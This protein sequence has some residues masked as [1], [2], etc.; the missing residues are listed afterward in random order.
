MIG[1][2]KAYIGELLGIFPYDEIDITLYH[3]RGEIISD[4]R[5]VMTEEI[6]PVHLLVV[7]G[8][9]AEC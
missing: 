8:R 3:K 2:D 5:H 4:R 7:N 1:A 9:I 6:P